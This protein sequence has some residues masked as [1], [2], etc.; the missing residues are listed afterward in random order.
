MWCFF[1]R[2]FGQNKCRPAA[3][4]H[5]CEKVV[6]FAHIS[7]MLFTMRV[8]VLLF[9]AVTCFFAACS[10]KADP[11]ADPF[12]PAVAKV[13]S[14]E[15]Y[16]GG[17]RQIAD[18]YLPAKRGPQ[19]KTLILLHGGFWS[20][21]SKTDLAA[22]LPMLSAQYPELAVVNAN[23]TLADGAQ[24]TTQ[25]PA[26]MS[27][28]G[29]LLDWLDKHAEA[30]HI[31]KNYSLLGVSSGGHLALLYAHAFDTRRRL[32][33]VAGVV[34]PV[35]FADPLYTGNA[36]FQT[37][38]ANY[39]GKTWLQDSG[40]HRLASPALQIKAGAIPTFLAYA[41]LD[42]LVPPSQG[43]GMRSALAAKGI[44]HQYVVYSGDAHELSP[45]T[46]ADLV[47]RHVAFLKQY[48]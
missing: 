18:V 47:V 32:K 38:A 1:F 41:G 29:L 22:V 37:V 13:L 48:H 15:A 12:D 42:A 6:I 16:G 2:P 17:A 43:P 10:K 3:S 14:A 21:G 40:L 44:E 26:Q 19:T 45:P 20:S 4:F 46:I 23:Y 34:A 24:A 25:H 7:P 39:L 28:I 9:A 5:P 11:I 31:G 8:P 33:T 36:L 27:D 30:W 35:N